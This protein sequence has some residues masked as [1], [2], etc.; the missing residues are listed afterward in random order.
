MLQSMDDLLRAMIEREASDLHI[1][2]GSPPGLRIDGE[3]LPVEDMPPLTADDSERLI[4]SIMDDNSKR[5]FAEEK[6]LDFAYSFSDLYRFRVNVYM[7]R[8]SMGSVLRLIPVN[9]QTVDELGLPSILKEL[10]LK[11][12]GLILVTGPTGSGKSTTLAAVLPQFCV[13]F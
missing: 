13:P 12:R 5:N 7:Q 8:Q 6:E 11:A 4:M 9:I 1:K 2:A 3:L 10:S